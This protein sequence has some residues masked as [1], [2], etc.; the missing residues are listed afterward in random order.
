MISPSD[1]LQ[2][3]EATV[4]H[5]YQDSS[6]YA[7]V[8][9]EAPEDHH[10]KQGE[11]VQ[12]KLPVHRDTTVEPDDESVPGYTVVTGVF[13]PDE[14]F[15]YLPNAPRMAWLW[16]AHKN[17]MQSFNNRFGIESLN[18]NFTVY[19]EYG[20]PNPVLSPKKVHNFC[21]G[22]S[23][24]VEKQE[25]D[26][27]VEG[28]SVY[29]YSMPKG[30]VYLDTDDGI[31]HIDAATREMAEETRG[32]FSEQIADDLI[33]LIDS[34]PNKVNDDPEGLIDKQILYPSF[35]LRPDDINVWNSLSSKIYDTDIINERTPVLREKLRKEVG[36]NGHQSLLAWINMSTAIEHELPVIGQTERAVQEITG[37]DGI[38]MNWFNATQIREKI[39]VQLVDYIREGSYDYDESILDD[40]ESEYV[41]MP[42]EKKGVEVGAKMDS[43]EPVVN[44][45]RDWES[46]DSIRDYFWAEGAWW[47]QIEGATPYDNRFSRKHV[48]QYLSEGEK[49]PATKCD[50]EGS[51]P[52]TYDNIVSKME[53]VTR[54]Y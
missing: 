41:V 38:Y 17:V 14:F 35:A 1:H 13:R 6:T 20:F 37:I 49:F 9:E 48:H 12:V 51:E 8:A 28:N 46:M 10:T 26:W 25:D 36:Y 42:A 18:D 34:Y 16:S 31:T 52:T 44:L 21:S 33:S 39:A 11:E 43:Y 2:I 54:E 45:K 24:K 47:F 32:N 40:S 50:I 23:Q 7:K 5:K 29:A 53:T 19:H 22:N 30:T 27:F 15:F 3:V 4:E